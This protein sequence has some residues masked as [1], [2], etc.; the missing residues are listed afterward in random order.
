MFVILGETFKR[1]DADKNDALNFDEFLHSDLPYEQLK[2]DEFNQLDADR[3]S[4][5]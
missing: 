4:T 5:Y 1:I 2:H 3:K